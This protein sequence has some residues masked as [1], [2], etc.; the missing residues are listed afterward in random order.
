MRPADLLP[1][2]LLAGLAGCDLGERHGAAGGVK[3]FLAAAGS[4]DRAAFEARIDRARLRDTLRAQLR[5]PEAKVAPEVLRGLETAEGER[6]LDEMIRP[7]AFRL[8]FRRFGVAPVEAPTTAE[9]MGAVRVL[10]PGKA[11][12]RDA[13]KDGRCAMTFERRGAVWTLVDVKPREMQ[14][15][16]RPAPTGREA[17]SAR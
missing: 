4:G 17:A 2:V 6:M 8:E 15:E 10:G 11:C 3:D 13:A 5:A 14:V 16:V 1:L 9:I 7:E 12:L